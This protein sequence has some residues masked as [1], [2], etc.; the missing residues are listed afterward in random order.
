MP[1]KVGFIRLPCPVNKNFYVGSRALARGVGSFRHIIT[2]MKGR[3]KFTKSAQGAY[4][5]NMK[6]LKYKFLG[7]VLQR[8]DW[9]P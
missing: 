3:G 6:G 1:T 9:A 2:Y 7:L 5:Y 4:H 8:Y